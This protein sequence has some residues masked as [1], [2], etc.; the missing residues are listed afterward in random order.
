MTQGKHPHSLSQWSLCI[1][2]RGPANP[3]NPHAASIQNPSTVAIVSPI[4]SRA[5][6]RRT[7]T[8]RPRRSLG[9][10]VFT[11]MPPAPPCRPPSAPSAT[12]PGNPHRSSHG[13]SATS[14]AGTVWRKRKRCCTTTWRADASLPTKWCGGSPHSWRRKPCYGQC[15]RSAIFRRY[16]AAAYNRGE[17]TGAFSHVATTRR[18]TPPED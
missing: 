16:P 9:C 10:T 5:S 17:L 4:A 12:S 18:Q 2:Q 6:R 14:P 15:G 7:L 1:S 13:P 3:K 8:N 11:G